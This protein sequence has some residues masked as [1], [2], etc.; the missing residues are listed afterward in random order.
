MLRARSKSSVIM[1][2][3]WSAGVSEGFARSVD[4]VTARIPIELQTN[5][6]LREPEWLK[7]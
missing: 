7:N 3:K 2:E 1:M 6:R 4:H 5:E